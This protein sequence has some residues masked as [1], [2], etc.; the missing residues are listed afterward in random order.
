MTFVVDLPSPFVVSFV[1]AY[2]PCSLVRAGYH[3]NEKKRSEALRRTPAS[4]VMPS[5]FCFAVEWY[6]TSL[7]CAVSSL[8]VRD[9]DVG[10][11]SEREGEQKA[12]M[13]EWSFR[14]NCLRGGARAMLQQWTA[15]AS[16]HCSTDGDGSSYRLRASITSITSILFLAAYSTSK[17]IGAAELAFFSF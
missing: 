7:D 8:A 6:A 15:Y 9:S 2:S 11:S 4:N 17:Y 5:L 10:F 13:L 12:G 14:R 1:P 16:W 3:P